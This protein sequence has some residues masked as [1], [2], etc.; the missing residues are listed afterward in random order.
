[1][2]KKIKS[3]K[4]VKAVELRKDGIPAFPEY[5]TVPV[6]NA[7]QHHCLVIDK[8]GKSFVFKTKSHVTIVTAGIDVLYE[9]FNDYCERVPAI[10]VFAE[11]SKL[12]KTDTVP[13]VLDDKDTGYIHLKLLVWKALCDGAA[14]RLEKPVKIDETTKQPVGRK[15]ANRSYILCKVEW[16]DVTIPQAIACLKIV[17]DN[18]VKEGDVLT[19]KEDTLKEQIVKRADELK[20]KQD[21]WRIF[22]YYRPALIQKGILRLV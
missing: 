8:Q 7:H 9:N 18:A 2:S 19:V 10:D 20:T 22:Q 17:K 14:Q 13:K 21:P 11:H 3:T 4:G 12:F 16:P 1:M 5:E 15:L 6:D